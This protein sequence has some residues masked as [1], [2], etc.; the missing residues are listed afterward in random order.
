MI[1][2]SL[3]LSDN[4]VTPRDTTMTFTCFVFFDMFNALSCRSQ[5]RRSISIFFLFLSSLYFSLSL[6]LSKC[7]PLQGNPFFPQPEKCFS[8]N[9]QIHSFRTLEISQVGKEALW[10]QFFLTSFNLID[11]LPISYHSFFLPVFLPL[12]LPYSCPNLTESSLQ[13]KSVLSLGLF[14]NK[15][16]LFSVTGSIIAQMLV[17]YWKPLQKVFVTEPLSLGDIV[18][19]LILASSVFWASEVKKYLERRSLRKKKLHE[20][21]QDYHDYRDIV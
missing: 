4:I 17:I 11:C 6:F 5:V 21:Y 18:S 3:Q 1:L 14:S 8:F 15:P 10:K 20:V 19:L 13:T 12:F 16:F 2:F 7:L 9:G